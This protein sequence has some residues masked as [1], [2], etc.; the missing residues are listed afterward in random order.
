MQKITL[1]DVDGTI[2]KG[3]LV[4]EHAQFLHDAG[5][6]ALGPHVSDWVND[7][8]SESK[9]TGLAQ[10]YQSAIVGMTEDEI[11][12]KD[13]LAHIAEDKKSWYTTL[14]RLKEHRAQGEKVVLISGSPSY[15]VEPFAQ[16][17]GFE[18]AGTHYH[19]DAHGRFT[20]ELTPMFSA[21]AKRDFIGGLNLEIYTTVTAYGDTMSDKPL[22]D[23]AHH[24]VLVD[25]HEETLRSVGIVSETIW[26]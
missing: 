22:F 2:R 10:A 9:I 4:L 24:S 25:P 14:D 19:T 11:L 17:F 26:L 5:V 23:V 8:K 12:V 15:L 7:P 3:S 20:G 21:D 18:G 16:S 13:Y 6:L 1:S